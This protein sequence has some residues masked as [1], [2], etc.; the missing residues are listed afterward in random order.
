[1]PRIAILFDR[2]GPY[3]IA[4]MAAAAQHLQV[5]ALEAAPE[6]AEYAWDRPAMPAALD[7]VS[8]A[9]GANKATF[10]RLL[11]PLALDVVAV[12]GWSSPETLELTRWCLARGIPVICMSETNAWDFSR[13]APTEF[14]KRGV[15]GHFS[16]GLVT[17]SSQVD[18]LASLGLARER[19]FLGYN[20]VDNA[21]FAAAA[22]QARRASIMPQVHGQ[23]LPAEW[24]G[25]YFLASNR[26]IEKKNL[27]A[28]L[29]AYAA[30][31]AGRGDDPGDW[32]LVMLG[33][34][35]LRP[36]LEAQVRALGLASHVHFPGFRQYDEL[37]LFYAAAG[38]FVHVSLVEQWGLVINEAMASGL[39]AIVSRRCGC[40]EVLIEDGV[41]GLL[42]DPADDA[43]IA[44]ALQRM[45][46]PGEQARLAAAVA[47]RIDEWGPAR[48][49]QGMKQAAA[50]AMAAGP[51]RPS[52]L[53]RMLLQG[54]S[55]W[56]HMRQA[57][58]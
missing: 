23:A 44:A 5:V 30:F 6:N 10:D 29:R 22:E 14:V 46:Q 54:A 41:N 21:Y 17:S 3:H 15:V 11:A 34:G 50:A 38:A 32:P 36:A 52:A 1:M 16:A 43:G 27:A 4:R 18:Y 25:R 53:Q 39:P 51:A 33:D 20:V 13:S 49:G 8:L 35:E 12:P 47:A 48:F 37:P 31:R 24:R 58:G 42:I 2:F 56:R 19:I 57:N 7:Y 9:A 40:T 55:T 28:L 45:A 26:F